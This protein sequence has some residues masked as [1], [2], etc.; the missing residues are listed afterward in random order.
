M[1]AVVLIATKNRPNQLNVALTSVFH[2]TCLPKRVV[3]VSDCDADFVEATKT[4]VK[5]FQNYGIPCLYLENER[6][7]NLSGA[8]NTGLQELITNGILPEANYCAI[9]DDD[10]TWDPTYLAECLLC[11]EENNA[12]WI[13]SGLIRHEKL[14]DIGVKLRIPDQLSLSNFFTGNPHIQGSNL[15]IKLSTLLEAGGFDEN[16]NSIPIV[17]SVSDFWI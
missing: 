12:D 6:T 16:L 5:S 14:G 15:F 3:V 2:Q 9:L 17:M 1:Q 8:I 13:I 4:V 11:G 10:D 7:K